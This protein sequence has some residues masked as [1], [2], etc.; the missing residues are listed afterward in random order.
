MRGAGWAGP[1]RDGRGATS[2]PT[3]ATDSQGWLE[4]A[5]RW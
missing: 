5:S 4:R 3:E 1:Q 2:D